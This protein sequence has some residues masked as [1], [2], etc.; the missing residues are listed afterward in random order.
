MLM[1]MSR[2]SLCK[3]PGKWAENKV[4]EDLL[5]FKIQGREKP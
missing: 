3:E 1:S 2:A 5:V 4:L